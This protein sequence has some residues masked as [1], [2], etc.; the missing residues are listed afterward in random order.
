MYSFSQIEL[1][2]QCPKKYQYKYVDKLETVFK[3]SPDLILGTSVHGALERLYQQVTVFKIPTSEDVLTKFHE[4]RTEEE[5]K[6]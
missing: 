4:I 6:A 3:T 1:Y 5:N 2:Q